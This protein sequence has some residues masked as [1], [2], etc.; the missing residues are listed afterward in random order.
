MEPVVY[1]T[2]KVCGRAKDGSLWEPKGV[3]DFHWHIYPEDGTH[4]HEFGT[5]MGTIIIEIKVTKHDGQKTTQ[6]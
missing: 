2:T 1:V 3:T 5:A 6:E 4:T